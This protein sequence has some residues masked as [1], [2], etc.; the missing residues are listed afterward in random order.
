LVEVGGWGIK[1]RLTKLVTFTNRNNRL[2]SCQD[3]F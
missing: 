2:K 3:I 1:N